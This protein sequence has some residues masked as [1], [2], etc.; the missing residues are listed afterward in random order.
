MVTTPSASAKIKSPGLIVNGSSCVSDV[1]WTGSF[2]VDD[3]VNEAEPRIEIPLANNWV[4][5]RIKF[6]NDMHWKETYWK[7][8]IPMFIYV[9]KITI[10]NHTFRPQ[11]LCP[12]THQSSPASWIQALW[13]A[14]KHNRIFRYAVRKMNWWFGGSAVFRGNHLHRECWPEYLGSPNLPSR[15]PHCQA[16]EEATI[17]HAEFNEGIADLVMLSVWANKMKKPGM[18]LCR[19]YIAGC[20]FWERFQRGWGSFWRCHDFDLRGKLRQGSVADRQ[21]LRVSHSR[22]VKVQECIWNWW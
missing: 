4:L 22:T 5:V 2:R 3:L 8:Q 9:P 18:V 13:L 20:E 19:T 1:N 14:Y 6:E 15:R 10:N 7:A 11:F 16:G 12:G 21:M 17:F